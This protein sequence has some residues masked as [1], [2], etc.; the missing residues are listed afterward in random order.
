MSDSMSEFA[1]EEE[2]AAE[3]VRTSCALGDALKATRDRIFHPICTPSALEL[4]NEFLQD[5]GVK[6]VITGKKP[7]GN[8][9]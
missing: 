5:Y 7:Q 4:A 1:R 8:G 3:I 9:A 2:Q 6:L